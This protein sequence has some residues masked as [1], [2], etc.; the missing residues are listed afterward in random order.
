MSN[1]TASPSGGEADPMPHPHP[2]RATTADGDAHVA[3]STVGPR[4]APSAAHDEHP[5]PTDAAARPRLVALA[6]TS[7]PEQGSEAAA[8]WETV[9][10]LLDR[11]DVTVITDRP[12]AEAI[13]RRID[14]TGLTGLTAVPVDVPPAWDRMRRVS[15]FSRT[16]W[17]TVYLRWLALAADVARRLHAT[18][19]FDVAAHVAYGSYWLPSPVVDLGIPSIWGPVGGATTTPVRLWRFL[20]AKGVVDEVA[21]VGS[22]RVLERLPQTRRTWRRATVRLV[23]TDRTLRALPRD[24]QPGTAVASRAML[25]QVPAL[26][27]R[28]R[29]PF[30]LFPSRLFPRKGG[31]LALH[32][33]ALT[34]DDVELRFVNG[35][36][37][38][39]RLRALADE[40]GVADRAHFLGRIPRDELFDMEA[41]AAAVVFAGLRE[42]GGCALVEAMH[43]GVPVI[44]LAHGGAKLIADAGTD[45]RRI[46][47]V[48][49][50]SAQVTAQRM[51]DAMTRAC[52]DLTDHT[53][54]YLDR[55]P[56][57]TALHEAFDAAMASSRRARSQ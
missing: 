49:P 32:A 54:S 24:L 30:V 51:A 6:F 23:E 4:A 53:G 21:K 22:M 48:H 9:R 31:R 18:R 10:A 12:S 41:E 33:L 17:F 1:T 52:H 34:P 44:V 28:A 36:P 57:V 42:E 2:P 37:D 50:G 43:M 25:T 16:L 46:H 27:P 14:A 38:E 11:A 5:S 8:A 20:G 26:P 7:N 15:W 39:P 47:E 55:E 40:L 45:P 29:R 35:G 56:T 13:D 3:P 19:P